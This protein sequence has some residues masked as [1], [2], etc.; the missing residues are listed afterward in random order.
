MKPVEIR[1]AAR[2]WEDAGDQHSELARTP[3]AWTA[4]H[5]TGS[6]ERIAAIHEMLQG[7]NEDPSGSKFEHLMNTVRS[8]CGEGAM[9]EL[10]AIFMDRASARG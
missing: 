2:P 7:F 4:K 8:V 6:E 9:F 5:V 3:E 1:M 10:L